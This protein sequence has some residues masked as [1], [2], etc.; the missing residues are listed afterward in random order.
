MPR[1]RLLIPTAIT[2]AGTRWRV[3]EGERVDMGSGLKTLR[4]LGLAGL[5]ER[6]AKIIHLRPGLAPVERERTF[7]HELGHAACTAH[8]PDDFEE[9]VVLSQ[10][11]GWL[12]VVRQ[13]A[14]LE[15]FPIGGDE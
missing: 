1:R 6:K 12:D 3:A 2:I 5:C 14:G 7:V 13:F 4:Q 9:V 15:P 8:L 11:R 10:E